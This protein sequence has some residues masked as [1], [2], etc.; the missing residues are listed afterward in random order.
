MLTFLYI[1][2]A[3]AVVLFAQSFVTRRARLAATERGWTLTVFAVALLS[4]LW[5]ILAAIVLAEV[6]AILVGKIVGAGVRAARS[7]AG[8]K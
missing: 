3:I 4:L 7:T 6:L 2:A 1:Y 5:P 8:A